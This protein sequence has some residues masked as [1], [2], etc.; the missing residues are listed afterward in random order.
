MIR[1]MI[2]TFVT[3]GV[4][5]FLH[6]PGSE[7][8]YGEIYLWQ[9]MRLIQIRS[10]L[11]ST[12]NHTGDEPLVAALSRTHEDNKVYYTNFEKSTAVL[13]VAGYND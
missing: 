1:E 9:S 12:R 8:N 6:N 3:C 5:F 11:Q 10:S 13:S 2:Q 7:S 4:F